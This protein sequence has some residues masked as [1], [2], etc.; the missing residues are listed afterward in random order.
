MYVCMYVCILARA[1]T[2]PP[3]VFDRWS[4]VRPT[5]SRRDTY[6]SSRFAIYAITHRRPS[7]RRSP[8]SRRRMLHAR[9]HVRTYNGRFALMHERCHER[10]VSSR[11]VRFHRDQS[12]PPSLSPCE[13]FSDR[14]TDRADVNVDDVPRCRFEAAI[15]KKKKKE[16]K[17]EKEE[18]K[19]KKNIT[20]DTFI[21]SN[22][23]SGC[24][25]RSIP[26]S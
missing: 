26:K 24:A 17:T 25:R 14:P 4:R 18:T 3:I 8:A 7:R 10:A 20:V 22:N 19:T 1:D 23:V 12:P 11:F 15:Y 9:A 13:R 6:E 5:Y 21:C 16:K 2:A